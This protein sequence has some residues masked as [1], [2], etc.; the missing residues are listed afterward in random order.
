MNVC[1]PVPTLTALISMCPHLKSMVL[2]SLFC[3]GRENTTPQQ[4]KSVLNN[5]LMELDRLTFH[6]VPVGYTQAVLATNIGL[7]LTRLVFSAAE[8]FHQYID[9]AHLRPCVNLEELKIG[10][11]CTV[12]LSALSV[13]PFLPSL[14]K[15]VTGCCL[16]EWS[17]LF[18]R[19]RPLLTCLNLSC[20]HIGIPEVSDFNWNELP[21]LWPALEQLHVNLPTKGLYLDELPPIISQMKRLKRVQ[22]P[23]PS[24][25]LQP[26]EEE[27]KLADHLK[28]KITLLTFRNPVQSRFARSICFFHTVQPQGVVV[29]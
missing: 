7:Q 28:S 14:K 15:L 4:V 13:G 16:G 10:A 9:L 5:K 2:V 12:S 21:S 18:E 3:R 8:Y 20:C 29:L 6:A 17:R 23:I 27:K 11:H 22:M 25:E 1:S 26:T 19:Q 24:W